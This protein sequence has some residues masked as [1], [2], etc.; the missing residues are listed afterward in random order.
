MNFFGHAAVA[1]WSPVAAPGYVLGSMLPDFMSMCGARIA[2][3]SRDPAAEA[4]IALHHATDSRFHQHP[5]VLGLMRELDQHLERAGCARGPRRGTAHIGTELLLDGTLVGV[6]AYRD[7]YTSALA[8]DATLTFREPD[9]AGRYA[10]LIERL[11]TYGVPDDLRDPAAITDRLQRVLS[12]R[13]L[14]AP[15]SADLRAIATSL[16]LHQPRVEA[17]SASV[18]HA[19][20]SLH[21][22]APAPT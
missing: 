9:G 21:A 12:R 10:H 3:A 8:H 6:R 1:S 7:A 15:T 4:G 5:L 11:R 13:P 18:M 14:L 22:P 16:V 17:A 20:R 2:D 19:L